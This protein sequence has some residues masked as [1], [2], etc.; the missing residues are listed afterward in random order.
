MKDAI[1]KKIEDLEA[2]NQEIY[3]YIDNYRDTEWDTRISVNTRW[4]R[5]CAFIDRLY[6]NCETIR[7]LKE[8]LAEME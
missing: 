4:E 5:I 1:L 3:A 8:R 6:T 7:C 2:D